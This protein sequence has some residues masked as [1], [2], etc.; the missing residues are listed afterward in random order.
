MDRR[1]F[2]L[3]GALSIISPGTAIAALD[4]TLDPDRKIWLRR[5]ATHE[6]A[7]VHYAN[8]NEGYLADGYRLACYLLRDVQAGL[9]IPISPNLL[10]LLCAMQRWLG[11]Y[12][13]HRPFIINSGYRSPGTNSITE[14]AVKN[15][16]HL[17]GKAADIHVD[18]IPAE[19]LGRLAAMFKTGGVGFYVNKG[20][21]H[22]DVGW[23]RYWRR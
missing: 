18:S 11:T 1:T 7:V 17:H 14:G 5:A 15:S 20:F 2:L 4:W 12:G 21:I 3:A 9:M 6:E 16:F 19:Y 23:V 10:D 13:V 8:E 22:V